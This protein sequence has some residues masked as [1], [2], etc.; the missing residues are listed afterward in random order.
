MDTQRS[1]PQHLIARDG[2]RYASLSGECFAVSVST[3]AGIHATP[4][5]DSPESPVRHSSPPSFPRRCRVL[6]G[7]AFT[8]PLRCLAVL[9]DPGH[10]A[11]ARRQRSRGGENRGQSFHEPRAVTIREPIHAR[12]LALQQLSLG[13][14]DG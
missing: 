14:N 4:S 1:A 5:D 11:G 3:T 2:T 13:T 12:Q 6:R 7:A 8:C 10:L 9:A